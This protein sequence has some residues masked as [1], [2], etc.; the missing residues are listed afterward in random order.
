[1]ILFYIEDNVIFKCGV[2]FTC[3]HVS[4]EFIAFIKRKPITKNKNKF[5]FFSFVL[6]FV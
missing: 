2:R 4:L 6:G 1:M 3:K 5:F